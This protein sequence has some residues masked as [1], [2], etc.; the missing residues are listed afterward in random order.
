MLIAVS[1]GLE[2]ERLVLNQLL[3]E[4]KAIFQVSSSICW[5]LFE[6]E[7]LLLSIN[8]DKIRQLFN[9]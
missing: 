6:K 5:V 9:G 3:V 7:I 2:T 8:L 4:P 1:I